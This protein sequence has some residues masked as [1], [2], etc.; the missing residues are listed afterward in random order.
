M[1]DDVGF[2]LVFPLLP[3][4]KKFGWGKMVPTASKHSHTILEKRINKAGRKIFKH[5]LFLLEPRER[6]LTDI[7]APRQIGLRRSAVSKRFAGLLALM[8]RKGR[9]AAHVNAAPWARSRPA[10]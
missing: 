10:S 7:E 6:A 8:A 4:G 2:K 3:Q 9:R 5:F 1:F